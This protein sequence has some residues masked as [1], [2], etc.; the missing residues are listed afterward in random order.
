[1]ATI[2]GVA[3]PMFITMALILYYLEE[4][5]TFLVKKDIDYAVKALNRI[6][7]MNKGRDD[8]ITKED[9]ESVL[10][11]QVVQEFDKMITP[12]DLLRFPSLR[13]PTICLSLI[14]IATYAM[15]YGPAL[16]I[17]EIGFDIYISNI[18]ISVA[19]LLT[20][21]PAYFWIAKLPRKLAGVVLFASA[22]VISGILI[23]YT[24]P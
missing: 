12:L 17:S 21:P 4:T 16:T 2:I 1:M 6:G 3:A 14:S 22:F 13:I 23:F 18:I 8:L 10:Y 5:P 19:D 24:K 20:Y 15:Y 9:I 11:N 7:K